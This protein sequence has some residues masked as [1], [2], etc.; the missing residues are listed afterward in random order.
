MAESHDHPNYIAIWVWLLVL[1]VVEVAIT[2]A[3]R[4]TGIPNIGTIILILLVGLA[5]VKALLVGLYFMHLRFER[6]TFVLI[7]SSPMILAVILVI[8]LFPDVA[9][10]Q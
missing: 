9:F 3:Y 10:K 5:L 8:A 2:Y 1:T 6:R 4:L 7:V